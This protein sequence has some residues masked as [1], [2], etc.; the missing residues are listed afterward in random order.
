ML[1]DVKIRQAKPRDKTYKLS[2]GRGLYIEVSTN[3][4]K[5]WRYKY[6]V[7][8][9]GK[10]R[11]KRLSLGV[12]PE[13]SLKSARELHHTAHAL[14]SNGGDP[15][16]K[17]QEQKRAERSIAET[18]G[19]VG[20]DW[21][22]TQ[23]PSWSET[24]VERQCRLFRKD[25]APLHDLPIDE[26]KPPEILKTL[27]IIESRGAVESAHRAK[28][29]ASQICRHAMAMGL[30]EV[31]PAATVAAAL[32]KPKTRHHAAIT[33]PVQLGQLLR[34]I[35]DYHGS[36]VVRVA[37]KLTPLLFMRPGE[38]RRMEWSELDLEKGVWLIPGSKTKRH[39]D[40]YVPLARQAVEL[41]Q[42]L[43]HLT[44]N[45]RFVFPNPRSAERPMSENA[46]LY[47]LRGMGVT[48]DE[49]TPH[50]F[51]ATAK[52]MM[53]EQLEMRT[54]LIEHQLAHAVRDATGEAYNRTT[55]LPQRKKM[56]QRW[57]DYL[58]WLKKA[59]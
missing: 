42:G 9:N 21:F 50:G 37:L 46:V 1:T 31:D 40:H 4:S 58:D 3:G 28:Q 18:F 29:V 53:E 48:R 20:E 25:L 15:S 10:R 38:L 12:Y 2:D 56:M 26:I 51:R 17:R 19:V 33:D 22:E 27:R 41:L 54:D 30:I 23:S 8:A 44:G 47:A 36:E 57:A 13:V 34:G 7:T 32:R 35:D 55:F 5:Y 6:R 43:R 49:A 52:T 24:H 14:V 16:E 45:S 39:R 59:H 11:E